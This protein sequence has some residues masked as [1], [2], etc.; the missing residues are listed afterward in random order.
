MPRQARQ[1]SNSGYYH[2]VSRGAEHQNIFNDDEDFQCMLQA[3]H[4]L[5]QAIN[6]EIYAYCLMGNYM[7]LVIKEKKTGDISLIMKRL[8]TKYAIYFNRKYKRCGSLVTNRYKSTPVKIDEHFLPLLCYIHQS[9]VKARLVAKVEDYS[10]SSFQE[11][12]YGGDITDTAFAIVLAGRNE[13][14][15]MH[16]QECEEDFDTFGKQMLSDEEIIR[17]I[18]FCTGGRE[19]E[20]IREWPKDVRNAM[21]KQLREEEELSIRQIE[22]LTGI[23]R[24]VIAKC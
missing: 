18:K 6:F 21:L 17:K 13:W 3:L 23:S 16:E 9:P 7:H 8:M 5:K 11:Y 14:L 10:Y 24:G 12:I 15:L 22:R 4:K 19:P 1:F 20:E 2:V